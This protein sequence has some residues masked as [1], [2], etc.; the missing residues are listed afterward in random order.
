M[1]QESKRPAGGATRSVIHA[2]APD[3]IDV[4][5]GLFREYQRAIGVDLC[6]QGFEQELQSLPGVYAAPS[7]LLLLAKVG[8]DVAGCAALRRQN[9]TTCEMKRL[10]VRPPFQGRGIGK[11]L[12]AHIIGAARTLNYNAV[13]LDTLPSMVTATALYLSLGFKPIPAYYSN[14]V[15]GTR[16]FELLL[17]RV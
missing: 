5:R 17:D 2:C 10:F 4:V 11:A 8:G 15:E 16:Y 1:E 9:Q 7:G 13:R 14:P 3:D 6:F 12:V